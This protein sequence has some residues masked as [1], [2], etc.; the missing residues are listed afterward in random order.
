MFSS[1]NLKELVLRSNHIK[2]EQ[3]PIFKEMAKLVK[4]DLGRNFLQHLSK[5]YFGKEIYSKFI[6]EGKHIIFILQKF[7]VYRKLI[8]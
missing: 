2:S 3:L 6:N 5:G 7:P 1:P 4:L 8:V